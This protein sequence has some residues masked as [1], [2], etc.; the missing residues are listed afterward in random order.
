ME[1]VP[2]SRKYAPV[3]SDRFCQAAAGSQHL[4]ALLSLDPPGNKFVSVPERPEK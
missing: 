1:E 4:R 2:G 3:D